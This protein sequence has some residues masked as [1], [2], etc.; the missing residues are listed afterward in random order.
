[1]TYANFGSSHPGSHPI[2][3]WPC[4][5]WIGLPGK[6][7]RTFF[8]GHPRVEVRELTRS[9]RLLVKGAREA[10]AVVHFQA[11]ASLRRLG[12]QPCCHCG[13]WTCCFCES[14]PRP[15]CAVCT[16]CDQERLL[17]HSCLDRGLVYTEV[18]RQAEDDVLEISGYHDEEGRFVT[19]DPPV[20]MATTSIPRQSDGSFNADELMRL[21]A[22]SR[23]VD[24]AAG[25]RAA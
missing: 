22:R 23:R 19:L 13:E 24:A 4:R 2:F 14:C 18:A 21:I 7:A 12:G 5:L 20:R 3:S 1:M 8:Q 10:W 25:P 15:P 16:E 11:A 9:E 6:R 17:C